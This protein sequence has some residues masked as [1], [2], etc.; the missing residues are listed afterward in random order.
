MV[1]EIDDYDHNDHN[2]H[3]H[4]HDGDDARMHHKVI[5]CQLR[6]QLRVIFVK[7]IKWCCT[8]I[9]ILSLT[10]DFHSL[11]S[12][13]AGEKRNVDDVS[14]CVVKQDDYVCRRAPAELSTLVKVKSF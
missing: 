3:D 8:L 14:A 1:S 7:A 9:D 6:T 13:R 4:D 2:N 10:A 5:N 11:K 12:E